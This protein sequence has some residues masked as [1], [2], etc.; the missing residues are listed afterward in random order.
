MSRP[1]LLLEGGCF[2]LAAFWVREHR[3]LAGSHAKILAR[4]DG[5]KGTR[6]LAC[7]SVAVL[8]PLYRYQAAQHR[9]VSCKRQPNTHL[10]AQRLPVNR[11]DCWIGRKAGSQQAALQQ[12]HVC[13]TANDRP[14]SGTEQGE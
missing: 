13:I 10:L 9:A 7:W 12:L 5:R 11:T 8:V 2:E 4:K 1:P 14:G 3:R 6:W